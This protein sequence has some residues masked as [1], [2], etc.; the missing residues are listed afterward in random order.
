MFGRVTCFGQEAVAAKFKHS[1]S[2]PKPS[3]L[4]P[5]LSSVQVERVTSFTFSHGNCQE[6][7]RFF[8]ATSSGGFP[9]GQ[10]AGMIT[11]SSAFSCL[12]SVQ[13][14]WNS[15]WVS[16]E[17][18][19]RCFIYLGTSHWNEGEVGMTSLK[20]LRVISRSPIS[21][22]GLSTREAVRKHLLGDEP[23]GCKWGCWGA[24]QRTWFSLPRAASLCHP[25]SIPLDH[26]PH[27]PPRVLQGLVQVML[28]P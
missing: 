1:D 16:W 14:P 2:P 4:G 3:F 19:S 15:V 9:R 21:Q 18:R 13:V 25:R 20:R 6:E 24:G 7:N 26:P 5:G 8:R 11:P 10:G 17:W 12:M 27:P 22:Q 28:P 23:N